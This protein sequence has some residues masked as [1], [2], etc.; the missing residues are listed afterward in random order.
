M[1]EALDIMVSWAFVQP[2][3]AG[4]TQCYRWVVIPPF[5]LATGNLPPGVHVATWEELVARYGLTPLRLALLAGLK[6]AL[7]ALRA[8]GCRRA[9]LDGSFVTA[10]DAPADFD[11]C[12]EAEDVDLV[13]LM[14]REP[15]LFNFSKGRRVQKAAFGGELF[16]AEAIADLAGTSFVEYFQLD[17]LTGEP[18][19]IIALNLG[20]LP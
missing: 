18:K 5:E 6:G 17:K 2:L 4:V 15:A 1:A 7:D 14:A 13:H 19:G 16:P 9:Y 8:A 11:A 20:D 10:K 3:D 12:W